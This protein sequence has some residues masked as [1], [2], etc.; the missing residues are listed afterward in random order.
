MPFS[1]LSGQALIDREYS[2][3]FASSLLGIGS[4]KTSDFI[5]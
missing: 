5:H 2:L 4:I 1:N 3:L